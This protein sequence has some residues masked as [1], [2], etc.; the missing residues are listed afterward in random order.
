MIVT[1]AGIAMAGV[2]TIITGLRR[3]TKFET[4]TEKRKGEPGGSPFAF[5]LCRLGSTL[6]T[7]MFRERRAPQ[8]RCD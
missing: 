5:L 1:I 3:N 6:E 7:R 2:T 4:E 8:K